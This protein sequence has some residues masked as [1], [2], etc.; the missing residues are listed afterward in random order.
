[1]CSPLW[2]MGRPAP[3][4]EHFNSRNGLLSNVCFVQSTHRCCGTCVGPA[5]PGGT[6]T[7]GMELTDGRTVL[8]ASSKDSS[9]TCWEL[10]LN[11]VFSSSMT[12]QV[13][14]ECDSKETTRQ[15][16]EMSAQ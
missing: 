4:L 10:Q 7:F 12:S 5:E 2:W 6:A 9:Y 13:E 11:F 16:A 1:M 14:S 8:C 3:V 15:L